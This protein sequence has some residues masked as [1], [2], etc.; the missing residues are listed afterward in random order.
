M[1]SVLVEINHNIYC[2][3]I[4]QHGMSIYLNLK[5]FVIFTHIPKSNYN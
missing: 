3:V 5:I 1:V 4:T 2:Y